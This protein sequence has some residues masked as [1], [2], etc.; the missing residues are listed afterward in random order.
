MEVVFSW[1]G[2]GFMMVN[3]IL[4]RD[5]PLVQGGVLL[6]ATSYVAI[7]LVTD[8]LYTCVDPRVRYT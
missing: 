8:L 7:N 3:A 4:T 2:I 1:P 6:I 5:F